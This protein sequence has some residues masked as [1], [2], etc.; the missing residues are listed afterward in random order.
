MHKELKDNLFFSAIF[1][2]TALWQMLLPGYILT[3][4]MVFTPK[5]GVFFNDGSFSSDLPIKYLF[6]FLNIFLPGWVI[7]KIML[8]AL[9]FC[10]F[11]L[12]AKFLPVSRKYHAN[13]WAVLFYALNPFVY[14]RF[15]A[16]H[17]IHLFAYAFLPPFIYYLF[18][19]AKSPGWQNSAWLFGWIFLIGL[20]S[21]HFLVMAILV[22]T[23]YLPYQA[24][25]NLIIKNKKQTKDILKFT[26]IFG[27]I[28]IIINSYWLIPYLFNSQKSIINNFNSAHYQAFQTATD[29]KIGTFFNVLALYGY[30]G[31]NQPWANYWLWPKDNLIFWLI[32]F[33][34]LFM[35][36][37]LGIIYGFINKQHRNQALFFLL[38]ALFA[39]IFSCGVGNTIFKPINQWLFEN[40]FF[41]RGFR[42][43]QKWSG[44]LA[45]SYT[46][47]GSLGIFAIMN[48]LKNSK[49]KQIALAIIFLIPVLYTY[50]MLGGFA[51][52][53]QPVW[54]PPSW[55][56]VNQIL[57]QD[58]SDFKVLFLPWHEYLSFNYNHNLIIANPAKLFFD[59]QIIQSENMEIGSV[60]S[61]SNSLNNEQINNLIVNEGRGAKNQVEKNFKKQ[62]IKYII[63]AQ[64]LKKQDIFK[65]FFLDSAKIKKI[66]DSNEIVLYELLDF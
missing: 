8:V 41:W 29:Q 60:F 10:L 57:N 26:L 4:D 7:Q 25:K 9:F 17:W 34:F 16:G 38:L 32:I 1:C 21:L 20:F 11:Y 37:G 42:D 33:A 15:L 2:L 53:L 31:E 56:K 28:F 22:L 45:L 36:I 5:L 64:D 65:Y 35:L 40:I 61:Q 19:F 3:I 12:A 49:L 52:Q 6:E 62:G 66:Y 54:Y 43:S 50:P 51:R 13:Y 47:F 48:W 18:K 30:W 63:W 24:L 58:K 23:V 59:K 46:Y 14:E 55:Q 27:I 39:F 44:L